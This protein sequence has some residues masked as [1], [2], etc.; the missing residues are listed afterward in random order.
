MKNDLYSVKEMAWLVSVGVVSAGE[1]GG[2]RL[3]QECA[4]HNL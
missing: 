1:G 2:G 3:D 4:E